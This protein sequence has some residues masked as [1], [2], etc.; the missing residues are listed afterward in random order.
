MFFFFLRL[1]IGCC[2]FLLAP[3]IEE[4]VIGISDECFPEFRF[5][6]NSDYLQTYKDEVEIIFFSQTLD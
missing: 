2:D 6:L 1:S 3:F 5:E 4:R